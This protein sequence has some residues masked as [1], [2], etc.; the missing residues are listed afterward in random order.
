MP[1]LSLRRAHVSDHPVIVKCIQTW[2][3]DSRTPEQARELSL[4]L[5]K[6]FLQF[7]A[8][9]SLVLEDEAGMKGFLV[10]FHSADNEDE[11]YIHFV[12]VDPRL[13]GQGAARRL[14]TT[15]FKHAAAAGRK[16]V[17][18]ITSTG[19]AGSVAFHRAMGFTLEEGDREV[20]GL[21]VHSDYDGPGQDRVCFR[22]MIVPDDA[23]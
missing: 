3:G 5:P 12:G 4:L 13:R 23:E 17:R 2:W 6:V 21:P 10:G 9:T 16:E 7:F 1:D 20:D 15:F 19:N 8:G 18:A 11:A 22:R 14:Y